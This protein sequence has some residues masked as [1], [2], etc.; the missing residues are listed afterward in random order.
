[1]TV[2]TIKPAL[3]VGTALLAALLIL[4]F[5][6]RIKPNLREAITMAASV[7]MAAVVFS[8]A[9]GVAVGSVYVSKLWTIVD[10]IELSF[11]TD[12]AGMVFACIASC[13]WILTSVYSIGY[14][15]GHH[16]K[17]Q[18]GYFSA[19]AVCLASAVG[20]AFAANL[21]TFFIFYEMLTL[22][23]YPLV[24]HYRDDK[25][26]ASGRK[27]L[28]YTLISGQLFFAAIVWVYA[29]YGTLDFM[30]GGFIPAG[31]MSKSLMCILFFMMILGG[32][33]KAGVMP[34]H[35]WLPSA[36]V[37]PT[38]V[39]ALLHAVAVVKA[40]AF[41]VLRVVLY[42]FGPAS[43]DWC[44]GA[45]ILSWFAMATI[46]LSSLVAMRQDN[47][48]ARLAFS[49]VGQLSYIVLG[50]SLM[51]AYSITGAIFHI[52]AHAFLKITLFM[53]AGAIFVNT[54]LSKIS[55]M[56]GIYKKMPVTAV[57]FTAASLGI[58]GLPLM[59]GFVSKFNILEGALAVGKSFAMAVL[60]AAA[61][62]ALSYLMPVVQVFFGKQREDAAGGSAVSLIS[63]GG[64][65][66]SGRDA[67]AH[68]IHG[69]G[70]GEHEVDKRAVIA[71]TVPLAVTVV[72]GIILGFEPD[73]GPGLYDMAQTAAE[74]VTEEGGVY[75]AG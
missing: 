16:E 38:P 40:G 26:K 50:I 61:L 72:I 11:K 3:A 10:G 29:K 74:A 41:C 67:A 58:A 21:I 28:A 47:L 46:L 20:I 9:P 2:M 24:V 49:T 60:I 1:M 31:S 8:M 45:E 15:R 17:N 32:A 18:T 22:A 52:S 19:F 33:V 27:Y 53:A 34:L 14:M 4:L 62:L 35:G 42:V 75:L 37:A 39:S 6:N 7:S 70:H 12:A 48:K 71:M 64:S 23:T 44:G 68:D 56:G 57:C 73:A 36:M 30:A 63:G 43:A 54:G 65:R 13:L 51:S 69:N 5:G 59:A 55:E 25:A 66:G